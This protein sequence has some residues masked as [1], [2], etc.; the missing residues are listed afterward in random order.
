LYAG[1]LAAQSAPIISVDASV[2]YSA[3]FWALLLA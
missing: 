1:L 3:S 2:D